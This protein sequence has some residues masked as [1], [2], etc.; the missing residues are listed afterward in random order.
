MGS[1]NVDQA[2][3]QFA[4]QTAAACAQQDTAIVSGGARG[5]DQTAMLAGLDAGGTAVGVLADSL[6]R[7]SVA[8]KFRGPIR[9]RRLVLVSAFIPAA[10][11]NVGN[12]MVATSH[13]T[14][15]DD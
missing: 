14:G 12:A 5:V 15:S 7:S 3:E 9:E 8:K 11:F 6:F 10:R 1:R 4:R 2:G 13:F